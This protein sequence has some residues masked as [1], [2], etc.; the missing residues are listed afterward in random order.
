[1]FPKILD[2]LKK[3]KGS[4]YIVVS[5]LQ[6]HILKLILDFFL[7]TKSWEINIYEQVIADATSLHPWLISI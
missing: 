1:M 2:I 3:E 5:M 4:K 7:N 6:Q